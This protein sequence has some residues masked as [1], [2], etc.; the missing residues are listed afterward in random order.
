MFSRT[1]AEVKGTGIRFR[2]DSLM[3][4]E[5]NETRLNTEAWF[6][7]DLLVEERGE[8]GEE[9]IYQQIKGLGNYGKLKW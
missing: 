9:M 1:E 3:L 5:T 6:I 2:R 7:T 4:G 8:R